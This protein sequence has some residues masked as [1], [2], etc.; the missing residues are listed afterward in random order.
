MSWSFKIGSIF[1]IPVRIHLIFLLLLLLILTPSVS[2]GRLREG[3][4]AFLMISIIFGCVV[5]HE[6][7]HSLLAKRYRIKVRDIVLLPIGGVARMQIP[8]EPSVEIKLALIGPAVNFALASIFLLPTILAGGRLSF[9]LSIYPYNPFELIFK[10]NVWMG[11]FNLIPAFP[12]DGGRVLRGFLAKRTDYLRAT[13]IAG[14]VGRGIAVLFVVLGIYKDIMLI[15]IGLFIFLAAG[16]EE[17]VVQLRRALRGILVEDVMSRD[18]KA[19]SPDEPVSN[20]LEHVYR[21]GQDE[22][23]VVREGVLVGIISKPTLL[24]LIRENRL[25]VWA[26]GVMESEFLA[27][28]PRDSLAE[29]YRR[30][31]DAG[32]TVVPVVEDGIF[33]G[34]LSLENIGRYFMIHSVREEV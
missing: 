17:Q 32:K 8:E 5:L 24:R 6:L 25:D 10:V 20:A 34:M 2:Q 28:S 15:A 27:V 31:M 7:G 21:L 26:G 23:P 1:G 19:L 3:A 12:M 4:A 22:F 33:K 11:L 30:M 14:Q 13:H 9:S 29:A 18:V 16:T